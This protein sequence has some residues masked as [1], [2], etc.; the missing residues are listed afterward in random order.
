MRRSFFRLAAIT[1]KHVRAGTCFL[2][3]IAVLFVVVAVE[4]YDEFYA[5]F[6]HERY[7]NVIV[8]VFV[9][10]PTLFEHLIVYVGIGRSFEVSERSRLC[11]IDY[12]FLAVVGYRYVLFRSDRFA[13]DD[14][15]ISERRA[16]R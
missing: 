7:R 10:H 12:Y 6:V 16:S 11:D 3:R 4:R 1:K 2:I 9:L 8:R 14:D 13:V 5:A 15:L